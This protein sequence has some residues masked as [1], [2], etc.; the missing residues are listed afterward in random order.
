MMAALKVMMAIDPQWYRDGLDFVRRNRRWEE[1]TGVP[2][3]LTR[4]RARPL[5]TQP[6]QDPLTTLFAQCFAKVP[7]HSNFGVPRPISHRTYMPSMIPHTFVFITYIVLYLSLSR[8][9]GRP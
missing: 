5:S 9:C 6:S 1:Q 3:S 4:A 8:K 7:H 2:S